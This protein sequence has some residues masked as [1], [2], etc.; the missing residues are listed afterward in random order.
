MI[1]MLAAFSLLM[2]FV[3]FVAACHIRSRWALVSRRTKSL[4]IF[5]AWL[6]V[7]AYGFM[8]S[9]GW[10][11]TSPLANEIVGSATVGAYTL[12]VLLVTLMR[13]KPLT[14]SLAALLLLP[15]PAALAWLPLTARDP[16]PVETSYIAGT[17]FVKKFHWDAGAMGSSGTTLLI[18]DKPRFIPFIEH[19]LQRVVFDDAKCSSD[20]AFVMLEAD[21]RH[22]LA[23]CPWHEY[24]HR[25]GFHDFLVPLF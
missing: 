17:L 19:S 4:L 16:G 12:L 25:Q 9:T 23:R 14:Y 2:I 22:V 20:K 10:R 24:Q 7:A 15:V 21:G 8:L 18:Y 13:P 6:L 1:D 5:A 3:C 11:F